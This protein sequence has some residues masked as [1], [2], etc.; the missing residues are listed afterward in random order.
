MID[1]FAK[2]FNGTRPVY[3]GKKSMYTRDS[4]PIG[5]ERI[6]LEVV[7]PGDSSLDRKFKVSI[8]LMS[9]VS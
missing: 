2:I 9:L 3:D 4:L 8:K 7:I 1:S 6:E 5:R